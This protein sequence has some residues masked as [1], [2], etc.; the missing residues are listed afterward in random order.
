MMDAQQEIFTSLLIMLKKVFEDDGIKVY[1]TFLPP[2]DVPYP[3]IY[4]ADSQL[5][6]DYSNKQMVFGTVN[7][8]I[9]VWIDNPKQRGTLSDILADIKNVCRGMSH[10][11]NYAWMVSNINQRILAD[12]STGVPLMQGILEI[13]F[14]MIG[15]N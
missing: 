2:L 7:Q 8:T 14:K 10:T 3:F 1:D 5:T 9:K 13:D 11:K 15:G 12:D 6:D 4:L